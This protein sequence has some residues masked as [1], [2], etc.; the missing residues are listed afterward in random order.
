MDPQVRNFRDFLQLYNKLT[1]TCFQHCTDNFFNR[2]L[3]QEETNCVDKCVIKFSNVNQKVMGIFVEAQTNINAKRM[4][5]LELQLKQ[6][7]EAQTALQQQQNLNDLNPGD[8]ASVNPVQ[9][10][11]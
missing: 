3:S 10:T 2:N 8:V 6:Q 4:A 11:S 1:E 7:Q 5:E 9:V